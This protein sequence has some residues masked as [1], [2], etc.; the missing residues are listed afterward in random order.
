MDK[1]VLG[2]YNGHTGT[3]ALLKNGE[4]IACVSEERFNGVKNYLGFPERSIEWCLNFA[5]ITFKDIDLVALPSSFGA[6]INASSETRKDMSVTI[7]SYL[8]I[9]AGYVRSLWGIVSYF[10]PFISPIGTASY[11]LATYTI[12]GYILY[13][14][15]N[16]ISKKYG[17]SKNKIIK[18]EH[19]MSHA[20][21]S[22]Y[23]SPYNNEKAVAV[24]LDAEG[25]M[26]CSTVSIFEKNK[27][28]RIASSSRENSLGWI[29][30]YVTK[31]LG[32]RP[33]EHEYKVMGLAPYAKQK[34]VLE[35]Y[36]KIKDLVIID[37]ENPLRLKSKFNTQQTY[38]FL[39]KYME[40]VRFD[41]VAG[42]FQKLVED[43]MVDLVRN[44]V[45]KT[46]ISTVVVGGGVFMNV[47]A[48]QLISELPEVK[49]IF[50]MPSAGD[51]SLAIGACYLGYIDILKKEKK[52]YKVKSINNL[53]LGP[54]VTNE[55]VDMYLKKEG[56][57]KIHSVKYFENI[58]EEIAKILSQGKV[59]AR[60][61]D[62]MEW[63]ARALG[64]RSI[65]ANPKERDVVMDINE[66]MKNRDFWMPFA[67]SMLYER[68]N[69][70]C[71]NL[72]KMDAPFMMVTFFSTK[73]ARENIRAAMHPYDFSL[74]PQFVRKEVS[75]KYYKLI[76]RFEEITG[77]GCVL[78]TSFNLHGYPIVMGPK[79]AFYAFENSG[80]EYLALENYL[81]KK[82]NIN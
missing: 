51:E 9:I 46:K 4:I 11:Q 36:E 58:E 31:Y 2:I 61:S 3:A 39:R 63:G 72:K 69:E 62:R 48:N 75:P 24:T 17:I 43:R 65:L 77:I 27:I 22:Y 50:F 12:G 40:G 14:E 66:K 13:K 53:Y 10:L 56:K 29:Y 60:V 41:N 55:E 19:H 82:K 67:P 71:L 79:E 20:A 44:A 7:I 28:K 35:V 54:A 23:A 74:R 26:K 52:P 68:R 33:G 38:R 15:K 59:V 81:I 78:N 30:I 21:T 47:K 37:P 34:H 73:K 57:R 80:I 8:Y 1:Y 42:A 5:G 76:K 25:D 32:M 70:Y 6:P 18:Y 16:F 45:K 49:K 64:N